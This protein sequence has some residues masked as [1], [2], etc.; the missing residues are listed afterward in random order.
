LRRT[1]TE[2]LA[3]R[4]APGRRVSP[5]RGVALADRHSLQTPVTGRSRPTIRSVSSRPGDVG[6]LYWL[7]S[8]GLIRGQEGGC[9]REGVSDLQA[10]SARKSGESRS[11]DVSRQHRYRRALAYAGPASRP[12]RT[13]R[14]RL[15]PKPPRVVSPPRQFGLE[16]LCAVAAIL[17]QS[18]NRP[19]FAPSCCRL[20]VL[21]HV[22]G[23]R[24][25]S[26]TAAHGE[27]VAAFG[28]GLMTVTDGSERSTRRPGR[29]ARLL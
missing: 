2:M 10:V 14:Q 20:V 5:G 7:S 21:P 8:L 11:K 4:Q 28:A 29:Q 6:W 16:I 27:P 26:T 18:V 24:R 23:R 1:R 22:R 19:A 3:F 25:A 17:L 12:V 13:A 9:D 15:L